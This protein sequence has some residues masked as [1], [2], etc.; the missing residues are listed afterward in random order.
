MKLLSI[1]KERMNILNEKNYKGNAILQYN[2]Y[3]ISRL[4]FVKLFFVIQIKS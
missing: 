3:K 1:T 4:Q 2:K